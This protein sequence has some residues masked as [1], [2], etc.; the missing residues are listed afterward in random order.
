M[1]YYEFKK[2]VLPHTLRWEGG[3]TCDPQ[4]KGGETYRGISRVHC[5]EWG[6]WAFLDNIKDKKSGITSLVDEAL[7]E[8]VALFYCHKYGQRLRYIASPLVF[9][10][11]FDFTIHGGFSVSTLQARLNVLGDQLSIDGILGAQTFHAMN[12]RLPQQVATT[13]V[14]MREV[15]IDRIA[16]AHPRF[17]KGWRNRLDFFKGLINTVA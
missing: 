3:Y 13:I 5:P 9:I 11:C 17:A 6:G 14:E 8:S 12:K 15:H 4:D 16:S 7:Y 2:T 1:D 10:Q